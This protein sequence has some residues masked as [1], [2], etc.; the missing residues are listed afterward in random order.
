VA[1]FH[2]AT[3]DKDDRDVD[4]QCGHH[5]AGS[6][7]IAVRNADKPVEAMRFGDGFDAVGNEFTACKGVAHADM[8]HRNAVADADGIEFKGN[9][10]GL[11]NLLFCD[12]TQFLQVGV[13]GDQFVIGVA[14]SDK[15]LFEVAI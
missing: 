2:G 4:A 8:T 12:S 5:H 14:D 15:R 1:S 3:G 7:F 13:A 6:D 11:A 10:S 9:S